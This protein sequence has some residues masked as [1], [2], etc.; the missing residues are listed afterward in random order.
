[1]TR[2]ALTQRV[3]VD[4][5]HGERR[6]CLDQRWVQVLEELGVVLVP[7]PNGLASAGAW[8]ASLQLDGVILSGGN[9]L[10]HLPGLSDKAPERDLTENQLLDWAKLTSTPVMG[11]CRGLQMIN[12]YLNGSVE[13]VTKHSGT[14]HCVE[15]AAGLRKVNSYHTYSVP[16]AALALNLNPTAWDASGLIEAFTHKTLP[17]IAM[18]WHPEREPELHTDDRQ[19]IQTHFNLRNIL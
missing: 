1:M 18:M 7:V 3:I 10:S 17:W 14:R 19:L 16:E 9:D 15:T 11:V 13:P 2:I 8:A 6:D 5:T 12:C 4:P